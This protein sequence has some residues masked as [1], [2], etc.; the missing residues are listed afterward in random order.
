MGGHFPQ[1]HVQDRERNQP[2]IY[3]PKRNSVSP[4]M[5][6]VA[7][8]RQRGKYLAGYLQR[9]EQDRYLRAYFLLSKRKQT[10]SL[11]HSSIFSLHKDRQGTI[12]VGTYYG[13]VN[14]FNPEVDIFHHY[15]ESIGNENGLSFPFVG[16][17]V[18]DKAWRRMDLYRRRWSELSGT[19][20][21]TFHSLPNGR[22]ISPRTFL[23]PEMHYLRCRKRPTLH[24]YSQ[25][26]RLVLRHS[27]QES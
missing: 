2:A 5:M 27:K 26:G 12:W 7:L 10:R 9:T 25:T 24:R 8:W 16:N 23:Q 6:C 11:C 18:E 15:T 17:M 1:R 20:N 13:G 4:A 22:K 19:G 14:Y 3:H 21:R